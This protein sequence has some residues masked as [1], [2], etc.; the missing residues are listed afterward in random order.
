MLGWR[1]PWKNT[2]KIPSWEWWHNGHIYTWL[3]VTL[4]RERSCR[5]DSVCMGRCGEGGQGTTRL[6]FKNQ[7]R[8]ECLLCPK[9][10]M[11]LWFTWKEIDICF[12]FELPKQEWQEWWPFS[13]TFVQKFFET[14]K[15][16]SPKG[17]SCKTF[18]SKLFSSENEL[19][20]YFSSPVVSVI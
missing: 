10:T 5:K 12:N 14:L 1:K 17:V 6:L 7:L 16:E 20:H 13:P 11:L 9:T 8:W 18:H 19:L 4:H 15:L 3:I 2:G